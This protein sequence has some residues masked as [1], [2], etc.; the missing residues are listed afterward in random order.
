MSNLTLEVHQ[1]FKG[2]L[3]QLKMEPMPT[4]L[5]PYQLKA[6]SL[7]LT[8]S[9]IVVLPTGSGKT[10]IAAT[11]AKSLCLSMKKPV[12]F[13][14]PTR[15]LVS[16]QA[17]AVR[18]Q[19]GLSVAEYMAGASN[20]FKESH[21]M[22]IS[23]PAAFITLSID[24][25]FTYSNFCL[26][27]FDEVHH[28]MKQH[29]Y[30]TVSRQISALKEENRPRILGL[31]ASLTYSMGSAT[32]QKDIEH[33]CF[34]LNLNGNCIFTATEDELI[35]DGYHASISAEVSLGVD[36]EPVC[37]DQVKELE[38]PGKVHNS[39]GDFLHHVQTRS[40]P[41]HSLS[42]ALMSAIKTL[43]AEISML[44]TSFITPIGRK[45]KMG[46]VGS[47]GTYAHKKIDTS[48]SKSLKDMYSI[49][50]HLYECARVIINSR[51][52]HLELG[53][54]YLIM[55]A[56]INNSSTNRHLQPLS[57][58]WQQLSQE[59]TSLMHL[60]SVLLVQHKRFG[61]SFRCIVFVQQ[62]ISTHIVNHFVSN[63]PDLQKII[64]S[65]VIYAT[66][67]PATSTL[68]VKPAVAKQRIKQFADGTINLLF[69]T[70]VAE[71][72]MDIPAANCVIR[73]D[74]IQ[75]PVSLVQSRGRARQSNSSFVVLQEQKGRNVSSLEN[76]EQVQ[77][78]V[79]SKISSD[80]ISENSLDEIHNTKIKAQESRRFQARKILQLYLEQ[81]TDEKQK[82]ALM[83]L[84][85]YCQKTKA[86]LQNKFGRNGL[87][88]TTT[89]TILEYGRSILTA[90][91]SCLSKKSSMQIAASILIKVIHNDYF[92]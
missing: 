19:T 67:A 44:D 78:N 85:H 4:I 58:Q 45:G 77:S 20:P 81:T 47:W 26:V 21:D 66:S 10:L 38:L 3:T 53:M 60:K 46:N 86:E 6:C 79:I 31:T 91:G 82:Q 25:K 12:L 48:K 89:F 40:K 41:I 18:L 42:L 5:R 88:F 8:K 17:K 43:E 83:V 59:F 62:R 54:Q 57:I 14:V 51:Q 33:L 50:E 22:I 71:E 55:N 30:R 29:P 69:A 32:I 90:E 28:V 27:I 76:A 80:G 7:A 9:C 39:L 70:S 52:R 16:Q 74:A 37:S 73:F 13:L 75:T 1:A 84:K 34:D 49:L 56:L 15:L 2:N 87:N 35:N 24:A 72:G 61:E 65:N 63:D 11:V 36:S 68:S 64:F 92:K 23:T